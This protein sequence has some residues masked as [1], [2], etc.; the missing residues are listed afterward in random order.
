VL[1]AI[2]AIVVIASV[3]LF[4][5]GVVIGI[6]AVAVLG[7]RRDSL[8]GGEVPGRMARSARRLNGAGVR[9]LDGERFRGVGELVH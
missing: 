1:E 3:A 5:G 4:L 9:N 7:A 8:T 6:V 2:M